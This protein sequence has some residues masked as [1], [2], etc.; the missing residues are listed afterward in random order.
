MLTLLTYDTLLGVRYSDANVGTVLELRGF[1]P[2]EAERAGPIVANERARHREEIA[3]HLDQL[4]TADTT[5]VWRGRVRPSCDGC[6]LRDHCPAVAQAR[7]PKWAPSRATL[8]AEDLPPPRE[9]VV[10]ARWSRQR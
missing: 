5:N 7:K 6:A 9:R 4:A 8:R 1:D 10:A 2:P 3:S